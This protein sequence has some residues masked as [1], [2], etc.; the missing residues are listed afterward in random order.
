MNPGT[1]PYAEDTFGVTS[2]KTTFLKEAETNLRL[3]ISMRNALEHPNGHSGSL[4]ISN[5]VL[6]PDQKVEEPCWWREKGAE[7]EIDKSSIRLGFE[8]AIHDL[9]TL[10]EDILVSW[11]VD[12]LKLPSIMRITSIPTEQRD[13][14][15]PVKYEVRAVI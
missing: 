14:D 3:Y 4:Q 15:C 9:L 10:A 11:A 1:I 5:F 6:Y 2:Q 13:K 7:R 8:V 12:N